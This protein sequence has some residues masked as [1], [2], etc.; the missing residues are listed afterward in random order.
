[1]RDVYVQLWSWETTA[2]RQHPTHTLHFPQASGD[3]AAF[4]IYVAGLGTSLTFSEA[5]SYCTNLDRG[6]LTWTM[7]RIMHDDARLAMEA[8]ICQHTW[9]MEPGSD[10]W[11]WGDGVLQ[12]EN[13]GGYDLASANWPIPEMQVDNTDQCL[14]QNSNNKK[15]MVE[16]CEGVTN[17]VICMVSSTPAHTRTNFGALVALQS[18]KIIIYAQAI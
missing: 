5:Q 3:T 17:G 4:E 7:F 1:M 10:G 14:V 11:K 2:A 15:W 16:S 13:N 9:F 6:G 8:Q 12:S 18:R